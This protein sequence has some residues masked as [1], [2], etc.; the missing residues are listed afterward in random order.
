MYTYTHIHLY[1]AVKGGQTT[2]KANIFLGDILGLLSQ[3]SA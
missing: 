2:Q 1:R 3:S